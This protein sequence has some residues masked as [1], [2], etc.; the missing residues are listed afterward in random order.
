ML[1]NLW[2]Y[3]VI[4]NLPK[5]DFFSKFWG[6]FLLKFINIFF[7]RHLLALLLS[8][9]FLIIVLKTSLCEESGQLFSE[10]TLLE[11]LDGFLAI[12]DSDGVI[13]YV[14]ESISIYLGLTQVRIMLLNESFF[15]F[16]K[17]ICCFL[18]QRWWLN[19]FRRVK[20]GNE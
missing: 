11:S 8:I 1:S 17:N 5:F 4:S 13:L 12:L 2:I 10:T 7:N 19:I 3:Y 16:F 20:V 6:D 9:K 18:T 15:K 14:S